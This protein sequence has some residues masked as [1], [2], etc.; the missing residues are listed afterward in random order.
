MSKY[1][2]VC[3]AECPSHEC[4]FFDEAEEIVVEENKRGNMEARIILPETALADETW[5]DFT[6]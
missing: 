2:V 4:D 5:F 1:Y 6:L 3:N